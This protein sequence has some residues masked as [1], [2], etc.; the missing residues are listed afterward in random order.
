MNVYNLSHIKKHS[1]W[2][3]YG[4]NLRFADLLRALSKQQNNE[5]ASSVKWR[6]NIEIRRLSVGNFAV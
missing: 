3:I 5:R 4:T 1:E 2:L 6:N